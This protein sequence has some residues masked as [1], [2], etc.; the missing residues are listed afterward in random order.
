MDELNTKDLAQRI[1]AELKRY[2][3]PQAIFAQ[4]VLCRFLIKLFF[5]QKILLLIINEIVLQYITN[6]NY[7]YFNSFTM[8]TI[9]LQMMTVFDVKSDLMFISVDE[10][11]DYKIIPFPFNSLC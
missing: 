11:I 10:T 6:N 5:F 3:I 9:L 8:T 4:R 7:H 1:S 2:S